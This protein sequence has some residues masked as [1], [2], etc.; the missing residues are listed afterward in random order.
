LLSIFESLAQEER[1]VILDPKGLSR[2]PPKQNPPEASKHSDVTTDILRGSSE[3]SKKQK[4]KGEDEENDTVRPLGL[5]RLINSQ[6]LSAIRS[7][8]DERQ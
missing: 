1:D 6:I 4:K 7:C 2:L 5:S 8:W 3:G